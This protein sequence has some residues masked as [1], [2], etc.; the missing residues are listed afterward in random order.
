MARRERDLVV[1]HAVELK[2]DPI[3]RD[4]LLGRQVGLGPDWHDW[5]ALV[6]MA[7]SISEDAWERKSR[8]RVLFFKGLQSG[9][10]IGSFCAQTF[11][12]GLD[13]GIG[14]GG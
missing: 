8:R 13:G 3:V 2:G 11:H 6:V 5:A 12:F 9:L 10:Q 7:I 1:G 4:L 14:A